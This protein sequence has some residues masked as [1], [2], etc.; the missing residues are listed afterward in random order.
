MDRLTYKSSMGDYG[1]A[2]EFEND[3]AE[4]YAFRNALGRYEDFEMTPE[5]LE[6]YVPEFPVGGYAYRIYCNRVFKLSV[7]GFKVEYGCKYYKLYINHNEDDW[8]LWVDDWIAQDGTIYKTE[9]AAEFALRSDYN[10][11]DEK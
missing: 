2:K 8:S 7:C 3:L 5:E 1:T 9:K 4:R 11:E 6:L 10:N